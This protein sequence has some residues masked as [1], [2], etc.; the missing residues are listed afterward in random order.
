MPGPYDELEK[1]AE[2]F[3]KQSKNEFNNKNF[4]AAISLLEEAKKV[5][6]KLGY[7]GKIGMIDKRIVQLKNLVKFQKEDTIFRNKG[8][9]DF[10]KRVYTVLE[11]KQKFHD[12]KMADQ[13]ALSPEMKRHLEKISLLIEKAEKEEKLG[14]Y[15][16]VIGRYEYVLELYKLIPSDIQN[17]S[18]E[19]LELEKKISLLQ[20]KIN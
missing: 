10:Q 20:T 5:Y 4:V 13:K 1:V 3:E 14:K 9:Q 18:N 16:R 17:F 7:Q 15:S 2:N 11:E 12:K 6:S 8:E 19:I